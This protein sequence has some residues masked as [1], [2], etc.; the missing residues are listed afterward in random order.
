VLSLL[1]MITIY[2]LSTFAGGFLLALLS[3]LVGTMVVGL[4]P[5]ILSLVLP[6]FGLCNLRMDGGSHSPHCFL[7]LCLLPTGLRPFARL[8]CFSVFVLAL[9]PFL[10]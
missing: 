6:L 2:L 3:V 10:W 5:P 7:G 1:I 9:S 4:Y 8:L